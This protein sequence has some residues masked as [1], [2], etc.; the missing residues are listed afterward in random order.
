VVNPIAL[1]SG[2]RTV[3][4]NDGTPAVD[5]ILSG[6]LSGTAS[7]LIKNGA[8]TL[9]LTGTN[10]FGSALLPGTT[11][12]TISAGTLQIGTGG[13][14]GSLTSTGTGDIQNNATLAFN[15][16]NAL[17]VANNITGS[18][19]VRQ[20]GGGTTTLSG[21][22]TYTGPTTVTAGTLEISGSINGSSAISLTN[23]GLLLSA[24]NAI[25][26]SAPVSLANATLSTGGNSEFVGASSANATAAGLGALTLLSTATIDFGAGSSTLWLSGISAIT[27]TLNLANWSGDPALGGGT[28]QLRFTSDPSAFLSQISFGGGTGARE[29]SFANG[30]NS[31]FEIVP[32]P[33]PSSTALL[34]MSALWALGGFRSRNRQSPATSALRAAAGCSRGADAAP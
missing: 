21:S 15:R 12:V 16:S 33:E 4:V 28:D 25:N 27:G 24:S 2:I 23:G 31:Y 6:V 11:F 34:G 5:G 1:N 17:T 7:S 20:I 26:D 32:V 10:T 13:T 9:A 3:T 14:A 22:N 19:E 30:G 18:G 29:I 8:G